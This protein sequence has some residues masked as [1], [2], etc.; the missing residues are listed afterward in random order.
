MILPPLVFPGSLFGTSE[1]GAYSQILHWN[2][3]VLRTY[4]IAPND[5]TTT[6][7]IMTFN[8]MKITIKA[9]LTLSINDTAY[10]KSYQF[11]YAECRVLFAVMLSVIIPS[12]VMLSVVAP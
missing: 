6:L 3:N 4:F 1:W 10:Q 12:V 5:G 8:I 7:S 9:N 11:H 2:E